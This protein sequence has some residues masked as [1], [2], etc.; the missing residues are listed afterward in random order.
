MEI[1][2]KNIASAD[3]MKLAIEYAV[4]LHRASS[5]KACH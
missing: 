4:R 3:A 5:S 1:A 2:G